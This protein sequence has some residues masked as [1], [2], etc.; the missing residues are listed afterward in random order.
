MIIVL[1][2]VLKAVK[3]NS[4]RAEVGVTLT[5]LPPLLSCLPVRIV[6][7]ELKTQVR[8]LL[9]YALNLTQASNNE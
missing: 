1:N 5:S 8:L 4:G 3:Q 6:K 2:S 9:F 7:P